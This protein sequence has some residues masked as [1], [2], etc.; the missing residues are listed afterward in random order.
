VPA[1]FPFTQPSW[2]L[3]VWY[4]DHWM[5]VLG[6]GVVQQAILEQAGAGARMGWAWGLGLERWAMALYRVPDI[7]VFWSTDPGV[8]RQWAFDDPATPVTYVPVSKFI[9]RPFDLSVW[10]KRGEEEAFGAK[11]LCNLVRETCGDLVEQVDLKSTF[12]HPKT[13]LTSH[14]YRIVYRSMDRHMEKTEAA[15]LHAEVVRAVEG[16][17]PVT[18][19]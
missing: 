12:K 7:R 9:A 8:T 6:C 15:G 13:G 1:H 17:L 3:E 11:D 16:A 4:Q 14:C 10:L 18:L 19:C 5:E 2:E